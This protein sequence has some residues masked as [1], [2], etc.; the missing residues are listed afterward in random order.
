MQKARTLFGPYIAMVVGLVLFVFGCV[1]LSHSVSATDIHL[2]MPAFL[3]L[4]GIFMLPAAGSEDAE[5][6][7]SS[8][9]RVSTNTM[10]AISLL[11]AGLVLL[12]R[13]FGVITVP[14]L[15]Y[16]LGGGFI[17]VGLYGMIPSIAAILTDQ[18]KR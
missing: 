18:A 11:F 8:S 9:R 5:K 7:E 16:G 2:W 10:I 15:Q 1:L 14:I 6:S 3:V 12:L 13:E 4:I 17:V